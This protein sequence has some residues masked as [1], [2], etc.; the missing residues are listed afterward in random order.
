MQRTLVAAALIVAALRTAAAQTDTLDAARSTGELAQRV[1]AAHAKHDTAALVRLVYWGRADTLLRRHYRAAL[2]DDLAHTLSG[3][4]IKPLDPSE[5]LE[6]TVGEQ[7]YVPTLT[8]IGRLEVKFAPF[9]R[10]D[11]A[12]VSALSSSYLVGEKGG[13]FYLLTAEPKR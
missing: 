8:P 3:T 2:G 1:A 9:T 7:A 13:R 5:K 11:G 6:Y 10:S 4:A 12:K